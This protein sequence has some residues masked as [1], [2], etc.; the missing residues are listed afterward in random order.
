MGL[1]LFLYMSSSNNVSEKSSR[2]EEVKNAPRNRESI[3]A[4]S[5]TAQKHE[6]VTL[7]IESRLSRLQNYKLTTDS[8]MWDKTE[9]TKR[10]QEIK[11]FIETIKTKNSD[12]DILDA[13]YKLSLKDGTLV[14]DLLLDKNASVGDIQKIAIRLIRADNGSDQIEA[15]AAKDLGELFSSGIDKLQNDQKAKTEIIRRTNKHF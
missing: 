12:K 13:S 14:R 15:I 10:S 3:L 6:L 9:Y 8:S 1:L 4:D 5:Q 11:E 7:V 2:V